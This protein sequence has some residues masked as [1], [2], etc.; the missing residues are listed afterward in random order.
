MTLERHGGAPRRRGV[1]VRGGATAVIAALAVSA[2]S[3]SAGPGNEAGSPLAQ[4][5]TDDLPAATAAETPT[6]PVPALED[7]PDE[8]TTGVPDGVELESSES[9]TITEDGTVIDGLEITGTVTVQADDVVI[10]NTRILNTSYYP[11][12]V[13]GGSNLVVEDTEIDGQG[14]GAAAVAFSK[15]TLRRVHIHNIREGPRAGSDVTIEDSYIHHLVQ[16]EDDH[17]DAVQ[18]VGGSNIVLRGNHLDVSHAEEDTLGNAAFMFGEED[19]ELTDCLVEGNYLNGGN[20][21]VNGGGGGT[22]GAGC[23]FT[24]NAFG[25]D[26]RYGAVAN[27]G[28]N[29]D[30]D[31]SNVWI[32]TDNPVR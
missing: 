20:Y 28:S 1:V 5:A 29:V 16:R 4:P 26:H 19:G 24:G 3:A 13:D 10:R 14:R 18:S 7:F 15:Y 8:T 22:E 12:R 11:I 25:L 32:E 23:T 21:T 17:V 9:L 6:V 2:C 27:L 30:W 31:D